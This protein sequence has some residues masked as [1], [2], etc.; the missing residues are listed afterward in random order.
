MGVKGLTRFIDS[1]P[2]LLKDFQLR[3]SRVIFDGNNLYHFLYHTYNIRQQFN[4]D[5]ANYAKKIKQVFLNLKKCNIQPCVIFDG[6][7]NTDDRKHQTVLERARDRVKWSSKNNLRGSKN[8]LPILSYETF[9]C[10]LDTLGVEH[11]TCEYEAD[12]HI[13]ILAEKWNC[14]V[15]SNDSDFYVY[16][17]KAGFFPMDYVDFRVKRK[18]VKDGETGKTK[19]HLYILVQK[20]HHDHYSEVFGKFNPQLIPLLATILGN[21][22]VNGKVFGPFTSR[23]KRPASN[24]PKISK[25]YSKTAA[26]VSYLRR[27]GSFEEALQHIIEHFQDE[28]KSVIQKTIQ[29]SVASYTFINTAETFLTKYLTGCLEVSTIRRNDFFGEPVPDWIV[30]ALLKAEIS[31]FVQNAL[32]LRR[33]ILQCQVEELRKPSSHDISI[34]IR[35]VI[36]GMLFSSQK[37]KDLDDIRASRDTHI[38]EYDR[39]TS[40]VGKTYAIPITQIDDVCKVLGIRG[41]PMVDIERRQDF[42]LHVLAVSKEFIGRFHSSLQLLMAITVYWARSAGIPKYHLAAYLLNVLL[43]RIS[44]F[45]LAKDKDP[46]DNLDKEQELDEAMTNVNSPPLKGKDLGKC[47][48]DDLEEKAV[49]ALKLLSLDETKDFVPNTI[50]FNSVFQS[51]SPV[52]GLIKRNLNRDITNLPQV[53]WKYEWPPRLSHCYSQLQ[54]CFLYTVNLNQLLLQ[55]FVDPVIPESYDGSTLFLLSKAMQ[56]KENMLLFASKMLCG[57]ITLLRLF[58]QMLDTA[59]SEVGEGNFVETYTMK[60]RRK[61]EEKDRTAKINL[62]VAEMKLNSPSQSESES[63]EEEED[64]KRIAIDCDVVNRFSFL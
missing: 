23:F 54:S 56:T 26:L 50:E 49:S 7:Y 20:Y 48:V 6:G 45:L 61:K 46:E 35:R 14:P 52:L 41:L 36:Y 57:D 16:N 9:R 5:Y 55:P 47:S 12:E 17:I 1:N 22:F 13:A 43:L 39:K 62:V 53:T 28:R 11:V 42:L 19:T 34:N 32:V 18:K 3:D 38:E 33:V 24:K 59:S 30:N 37:T 58:K 8:L 60:R 2:G 29:D 21:D 64:I 44:S 4:G 25:R 63:S 40:D 27:Y 31:P 15:I 10:I 51:V